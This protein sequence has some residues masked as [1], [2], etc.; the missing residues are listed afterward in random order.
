MK[1]K[2]LIG[3]AWYIKDYLVLKITIG[4]VVEKKEVKQ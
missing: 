2:I 1:K 3:V 4:G